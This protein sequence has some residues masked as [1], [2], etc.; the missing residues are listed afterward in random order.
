MVLCNALGFS[1]LT[2]S[3]SIVS[4]LFLLSSSFSSFL[5]SGSSSFDLI[6]SFSSSLSLLLLELL[7]LLP[8][9]DRFL[10][11]STQHQNKN[12]HLYY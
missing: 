12:S 4:T 2:V 8:E 3:S 10:F 5:S 7:L 9:Y 6:S 11:F 1:G